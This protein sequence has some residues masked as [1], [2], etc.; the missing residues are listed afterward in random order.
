MEYYID[1][2]L[3]PITEYEIFNPETKEKLFA[4]T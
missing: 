3:I 2:F 1:D 4:I